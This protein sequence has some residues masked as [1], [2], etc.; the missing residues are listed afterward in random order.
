MNLTKIHS[1]QRG[2]ISILTGFNNYPEATIFYTKSG[3]CR[4][5]CI[6]NIHD[7]YI[8]VLEGTVDYAFGTKS[9]NKVHKI[10]LNDG[11]TH[12]IPKGTPHYFYSVT[13]SMVMEWGASP[14]EKAIKHELFRKIVNVSNET[15]EA[16][17]KKEHKT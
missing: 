3:Y 7:E 13:D 16:M 5:G 1:D 17:K 2:D 6:H 15:C 9:G 11:E 14:E 4:G 10:R 12:Q 8:C